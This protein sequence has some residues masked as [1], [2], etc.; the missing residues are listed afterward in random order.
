MPEIDLH[1]FTVFPL[2]VSKSW[3]IFKNV[4]CMVFWLFEWMVGRGRE[5][6]GRMVVFGG[7]L[8]FV[9]KVIKDHSH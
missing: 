7:F 5:G 1:C 4:F 6:K 9:V 8:K 2:L 3:Y